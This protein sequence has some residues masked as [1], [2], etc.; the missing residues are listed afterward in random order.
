MFDTCSQPSVI[1]SQPFLQKILF[2]T[3]SAIN[4]AL[5]W[6]KIKVM[7]Y[8]I[9]WGYGINIRYQSLLSGT[10]MDG[11]QR[12]DD[13][14]CWRWMAAGVGDGWQ[15]DSR[16]WRW[17]TAGVADG[18]QVRCRRWMTVC[19]GDGWQVRCRRWMAGQMS[20]MDGSRCWRW[21]AGQVSEMDD[22][23]Y[24]NF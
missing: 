20:E 6:R 10:Y 5:T 21:M 14:R 22:R 17:M 3:L 12:M 13:G 8:T 18:R 7:K 23:S 24:S 9:D 15:Q 4:F 11:W 19:V 16:C 2:L 1:S